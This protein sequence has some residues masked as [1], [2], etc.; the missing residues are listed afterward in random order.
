MEYLQIEHERT[1]MRFDM[2]EKILAAIKSPNIRAKLTYEVH[3][4]LKK[5][6]HDRCECEM[7]DNRAVEIYE[8]IS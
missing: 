2:A 5:N 8:R 7:C 1:S 4:L 6:K 3:E